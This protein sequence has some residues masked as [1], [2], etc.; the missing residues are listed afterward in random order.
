MRVHA[1]QEHKRRHSMALLA[2]MA[3]DITPPTPPLL[4][5][6]LPPSQQKYQVSS[7]AKVTSTLHAHGCGLCMGLPCGSPWG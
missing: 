5:L 7:R 2:Q 4:G 1:S 6:A 3:A